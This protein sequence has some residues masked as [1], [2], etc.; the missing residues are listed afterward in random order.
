MDYRNY[1]NNHL[2]HIKG[3][4]QSSFDMKIQ[5][6]AG[7]EICIRF[8]LSNEHFKSIEIKLNELGRFDLD[9]TLLIQLVKSNKFSIKEQILLVFSWGIYFSLMKNTNGN[10]LKNFIEFLNSKDDNYFL[11]IKETIQN[12]DSNCESQVVQLCD[13][14]FNEFKIPGISYAYFTKLFFFFSDGN[15][16]PILDNWL[17]KAFVF[18]I[19]NDETL[20]EHVK[21]RLTK[22]I[23]KTNPFVEKNKVFRIKSN[24]NVGE[25]YFNYVQ[26][27]TKKS[28]LLEVTI[29]ELETFLFGW[30]LKVKNSADYLNPRITYNNFFKEY[31]DL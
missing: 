9:R 24:K 14:F 10:T 23:Y 19:L 17:S 29:C 25:T 22:S 21:K 13:K 18:L 26:Y 3:I 2:N 11:K 28:E 30:N 20:S 8:G 12:T 7:N 16:L 31:F 27:L 6:A 1:L 15:N 5:L 4:E